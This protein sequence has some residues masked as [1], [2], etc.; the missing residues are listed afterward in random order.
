MALS[1]LEAQPASSE[2]MKRE[3][4]D[5][6]KVQFDKNDPE[7]PKNFSSLYKVWLVFQMSLLTMCGALGSSIISPGSQEI[8]KYTGVSME[9]TSLT[10]ALFVLG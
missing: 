1:D 9:V 7:D 10:V 5:A 4:Q 8:A 2:Q 6:F 3:G